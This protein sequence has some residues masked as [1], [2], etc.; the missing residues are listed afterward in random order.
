MQQL[1]EL[2]DEHF[3]ALYLDLM[4]RFA[5]FVQ[6]VPKKPTWALGSFLNDGL[7]RAWRGLI[8]LKERQPLN[9]NPALTYLVYSALLLRDLSN[10]ATN[11]KIVVCDEEGVFLADWLPANG[12]ML[13]HGPYYRL[14]FRQSIQARMANEI[15]VI[16]ARQLMPAE[17][18]NWLASDDQLLVDW[19]LALLDESLVG[20]VLAEILSIIRLDTEKLDHGER[21]HLLE[22]EYWL[23]PLDPNEKMLPAILV[24]IKIATGTAVGEAFLQWLQQGIA[25]GKFRVNV[26]DAGLHMVSEGL[27]I[28]YP[29]MFRQF[30]EQFNKPLHVVFTQF[31]N[32]F[33]FVKQGGGD[34]RFDQFFSDYGDTAARKNGGFG[35]S[36]L[37]GKE[38][39]MRKGMVLHDARLAFAGAVPDVSQYLKAEQVQ[40]TAS[41]KLPSLGANNK[42]GPEFKS[43]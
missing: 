6:L 32:L 14:F 34:Y 3:N 16:Y 17:G 9:Q 4:H 38:A 36:P 8:L 42:P 30:S 22:Q 11:Q 20:G 37:A 5:E 43:K 12:S 41:Q 19:L 13:N 25:D 1:V 39:N 21:K 2:D 7:R 24:N 26:A 33:G 35:F 23:D 31:G 27:F 28:E 40:K 15:T 10:I 29:D 18:F